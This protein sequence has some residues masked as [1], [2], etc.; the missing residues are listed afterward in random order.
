MNDIRRA[1]DQLQNETAVTTFL[2]CGLCSG[3]D[4]AIATA[5]ADSRV[6][7]LILIDSHSYST[8][9][10]RRRQLLGRLRQAA[11]WDALIRRGP[12]LLIR[13]TRQCATAVL[14]ALRGYGGGSVHAPEPGRQAPPQAEFAEQTLRLVDRGVRILFI[15]SGANGDRYNHQDQLFEAFPELRGRVARAYFPK[16][17]HV[18]T[19]TREREAL[20][21]VITSWCRQHYA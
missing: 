9:G 1:M 17:N 5:I 13:R 10:S 11:S 3:A 18:F 16:A 19:D 14:G 15:Y 7:G 2:I 21:S 20:L 4:N 12:K 8:P 6:A